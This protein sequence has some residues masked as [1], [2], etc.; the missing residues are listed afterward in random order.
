MRKKI[1]I[2]QSCYF[3]LLLIILNQAPVFAERPK[4]TNDDCQKCHRPQSTAIFEDGEAH[5][6]R[7]TCMGCHR[8]HLPKGKDT[9]P[10][11]SDCHK[12]AAKSHFSIE[13]S[14]LACHRDPHR[15]LVIAFA[16]TIANKPVC[17]SCHPYQGEEM[18]EF[19]SAHA[20][21]DCSFC[22]PVHRS[23]Q[24][25]RTCHQPHVQGMEYNTCLRCHKPHKPMDIIWQSDI[26]SSYCSSCHPKQVELQKNNKNKH[27][28][29]ICVF[30]H[31]FGHSRDLL[32][33]CITCHGP[34]HDRTINKAFA[35]CLRCHRDPHDLLI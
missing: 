6:S 24:T 23:F 17:L 28:G 31:R 1:V 19:P 14:C 12:P 2:V 27:G 20:Q 5:R 29:F 18:Q 3:A 34:S 11:C 33:E 7:V 26:P 15:P 8:E 9:I 32:P 22:H 35:A 21:R 13:E 4:L 25:C 30:C 10:L 16:D